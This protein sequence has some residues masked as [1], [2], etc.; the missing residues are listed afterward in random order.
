MAQGEG[1]ITGYGKSSP[2]SMVYA[3]F[4]EF[5]STQATSYKGKRSNII[6]PCS[7]TQI[8]LNLE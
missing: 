3:Y 1:P 6:R 2:Q 5:L 8:L 4:N 7:E